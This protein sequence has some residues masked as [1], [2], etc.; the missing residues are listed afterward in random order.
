[1]RCEK[2][3]N[4]LHYGAKY[5]ISCGEKVGDE[6][7]AEDYKKTIWGK[8]DK[9]YNVYNTLTLKKFTG[10]IIFK[11]LLLVLIGVFILNELYG[12][13]ANIRLLNSDY[14]TITY[15]EAADVYLLKTSEEKIDLQFYVP[16]TAEKIAFAGYKQGNAE[17]N[18]FSVE[19]YKKTGYTVGKEEFDY[20]IAT[21]KR[22]DK[23]IDSVRLIVEAE[24]A[25]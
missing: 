22:G 9:A 20:I 10:H 19:E 15:A 25:E 13:M 16:I 1:M 2:C 23:E 5:C 24:V 12:D 14:Y 11:I 17:T 21:T 18:E 3:D 4:Q 6:A 8:L 7:Y